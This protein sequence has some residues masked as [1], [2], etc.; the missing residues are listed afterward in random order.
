MTMRKPLAALLAGALTASLLAVCPLSASAEATDL[1]GWWPLNEGNGQVAQDKSGNNN[2]GQIVGPAWAADPEFGNVLY[3]NGDYQY[4]LIKSP[5]NM[6]FSKGFT[7]SAWIKAENSRQD[8]HAIFSKGPKI[9]G[10]LEFV[11]NK[12]SG[13]LTFWGPDVAGDLSSAKTVD[14]NTWHHIAVTYDNQ[15]IRYYMDGTVIRESEATGQIFDDPYTDCAIGA[16]IDQ[17]FTFKGNILDVR[18]YGSAQSEDVIKGLA[19]K[20]E[21]SEPPVT[22]APTQEPTVPSSDGEAPTHPTSPGSADQ[23]PGNA[24]GQV[25]DG[26]IQLINQ[27]VTP[28][29]WL[30]IGIGLLAVLLIENGILLVR[31]MMKKKRE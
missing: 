7:L 31:F 25:K 10:H 9:E 4:V 8:Y 28:G 16:L 14:D 29:I 1:L 6:N 2:H 27:T 17:A 23:N 3:F 12:D 26:D 11:I 15:K 30:Y 20:P 19:E 21:K 22:E 24:V 5:Q 13:E 18:I